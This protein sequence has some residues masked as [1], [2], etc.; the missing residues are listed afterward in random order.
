[1]VN[2]ADAKSKLQAYQHRVRRAA[3]GRERPNR[4]KRPHSTAPDRR[5]SG[6]SR[7]ETE[8]SACRGEW[9]RGAHGPR[10]RERLTCVSEGAR[11]ERPPQAGPGAGK[12]PGLPCLR[13]KRF[14]FTTSRQD[15]ANL[16]E[17]VS[18]SCIAIGNHCTELRT[19]RICVSCIMNA[20]SPTA[21]RSGGVGDTIFPLLGKSAELPSDPFL[22]RRARCVGGE[23]A[24]LTALHDRQECAPG[25]SEPPGRALTPRSA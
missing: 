11:G 6:R 5:Q 2:G 25:G 16:H 14:R 12:A 24:G 10:K 22:A 1:V 15:A 3:L 8:T 21:K 17:P 23:E 9:R 4:A 20:R 13:T 19:L 18:K 7:H